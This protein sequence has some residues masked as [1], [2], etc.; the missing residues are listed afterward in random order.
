MMP[1]S[2]VGAISRA[3]PQQAGVTLIEMMI[4]VTII[5]LVAGLT[6]PSIAAGFDSLR[7]RSASNSIVSFLDTALD[8]ADRRQQVVEIRISP[9]ENALIAR[10]ADLG[11][12]RRLDI[13]DGIHIAA[14]T[15]AIEGEADE[16]RRFLVYPGGAVPRISVE[17]ANQEGRHRWVTIDPVTGVPAAGTESQ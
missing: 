1:T 8:R 17:L 5:A 11:F 7:L 13:P 4:V 12:V 15:P 3:R 16:P 10:S 14:V 9:R 6:Y 2:S